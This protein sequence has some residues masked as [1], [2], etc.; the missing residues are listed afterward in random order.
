MTEQRIDRRKK[1]EAAN[2][3]RRHTVAVDGFSDFERKT[4]SS[5]FRLAARRSPSYLEVDQVD[6]CDFVIADADHA[7]ALA[8]ALSAGRMQVTV[9][10]GKQAPQGAMAWLPRPISPM[11]IVRELDSLVVQRDTLPDAPEPAG[12][13]PAAKLPPQAAAPAALDRT[14]TPPSPAAAPGPEVLVVEDSPVARRFLQLRLQALGYSV[15]LASDAQDALTWLRRQPFA[16][17]FVDVVLGPAGGLDGFNL[18]QMLKQDPAFAAARS[19]K[20][21]IVSSLTG[22][23]DRVR[24]SLAGCDAYL[25]KPLDEA[26]FKR[27]LMTLDATLS[28]R[29]QASQ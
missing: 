8:N 6:R 29:L 19:A 12:E 22:A 20:V 9:F 24:G 16:M 11:N 10:I 25:T 4:L 5:F 1:K 15:S 13:A 21:V 14:A 2:R 27:T 17:V 7:P 18:C 28:Q 26:E 23:M 3:P